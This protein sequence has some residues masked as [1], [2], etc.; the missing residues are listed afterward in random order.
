VP[1]HLFRIKKIGGRVRIRGNFIIQS[2]SKKLQC[3]GI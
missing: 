2:G 3:S 1:Y